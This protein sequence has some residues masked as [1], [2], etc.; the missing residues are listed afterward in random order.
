MQR[1][2]SWQGRMIEIPAEYNLNEIVVTPNNPGIIII[3]SENQMIYDCC[4][5]PGSPVPQRVDA[6]GVADPSATAADFKIWFSQQCNAVRVGSAV[7]MNGV[8]S[9]AMFHHLTV[10]EHAQIRARVFNNV[11]QWVAAFDVHNPPISCGTWVTASGA[12]RGV[13]ELVHDPQGPFRS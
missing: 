6:A 2:I 12:G 5:L 7:T 10:T 13:L 11:L 8:P 9:E 4:G 1:K 3:F